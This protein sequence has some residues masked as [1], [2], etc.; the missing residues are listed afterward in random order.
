MSKGETASLL[1]RSSS[2]GSAGARRSFNGEAVKTIGFFGSVVL[3]SKA[4]NE[5]E[6]TDCSV[7]D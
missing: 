5:P 2:F 1:G 4:T 7:R 6:I 3:I